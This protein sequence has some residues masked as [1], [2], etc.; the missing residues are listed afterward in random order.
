MRCTLTD[1]AELH[2]NDLDLRADGQVVCMRGRSC[3]IVAK[4]RGSVPD[5]GHRRHHA[6]AITQKD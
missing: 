1:C 5:L 4:S 3:T 2:S 6:I